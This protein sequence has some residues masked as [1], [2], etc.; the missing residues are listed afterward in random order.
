MEL[1]Q[2]FMNNM[3]KYRKEK[4]L[5]QERLAE[6]CGTDPAYIGQLETGRRCPSMV[7]IEKIAAAL[8]IAPYLLLY[9]ESSPALDR[10]K[11]DAMRKEAFTRTLIEE[12]GG[13]IRAFIGEYL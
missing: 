1:Q 2:I 4:G 13:R 7:Y 11:L 12:V 9:D 8:K 10:G 5:T 6:L 3:K